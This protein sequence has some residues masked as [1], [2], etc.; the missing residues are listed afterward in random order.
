MNRSKARFSF[1][2]YI[3]N[4]PTKWGFKLWCLCNSSKGFTVKFSVYRGKSGE[5]S[6]KEGLSYDVVLYLMKDY[7][8]QGRVLYFD[9]FYTSPT[10]AVDLFDQK[11]HVTC[12]LDKTRNGVPVKHILCW[13]HCQIQTLAEARDIMQGMT[14]LFIVHG[15]I[16]RAL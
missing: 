4:K 3:R 14:V 6:S 13:K 9:N 7:L 2:Q 15:K 11:T 8:E 12:T 5:I 16:L 1:K 10:L